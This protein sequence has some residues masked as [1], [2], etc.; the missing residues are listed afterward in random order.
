MAMLTKDELYHLGG[1]A[2][3]PRFSATEGHNL[4]R[5]LREHANALA[6]LETADLLIHEA[7]SATL[8]D[9]RAE[10]QDL[11]DDLAVYRSGRGR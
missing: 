3:S 11:N 2:G 7:W 9:P 8:H 6:A 1:I 10:I 5:L 4:I